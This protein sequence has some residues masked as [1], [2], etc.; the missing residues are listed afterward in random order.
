MYVG[1]EEFEPWKWNRETHRRDLTQTTLSKRCELSTY[2]I[3]G[4]RLVE[5]E[6]NIS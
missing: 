2:I 6:H 5:V 1:D 3:A 4:M